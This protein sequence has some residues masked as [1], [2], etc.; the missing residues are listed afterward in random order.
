[1]I[2]KKVKRQEKYIL[3]FVEHE[4]ASHH[5]DFAEY[6][7]KKGILKRKISG[8]SMSLEGGRP[9]PCSSP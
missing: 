3:T 1:M 4:G 6:I 9:M 5:N 2:I 7:I 8:G